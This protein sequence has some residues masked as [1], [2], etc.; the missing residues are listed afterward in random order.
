MIAGVIF[1]CARVIFAHDANRSASAA[2][3]AS[4]SGVSSLSGGGAGGA[5]FGCACGCSAGAGAG[6]AVGAGAVDGSAGCTRALAAPGNPVPA[7]VTDNPAHNNV[8]DL[9]LIR[10]FLP[11]EV[12]RSR[13]PDHLT[14]SPAA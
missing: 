9:K 1:C 11:N 7:I 13:E 4:S 12:R 2:C 3:A 14:R 6:A 10:S 8:V 5:G